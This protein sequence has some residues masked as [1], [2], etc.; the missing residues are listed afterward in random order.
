MNEVEMLRQLLRSAWGR[1]AELQAK[2]NM[3]DYEDIDNHSAEEVKELQLAVSSLR[4]VINELTKERDV[5]TNLI[6]TDRINAVNT[7][8]YKQF[9]ID[10]QDHKVPSPPSPPLPPLWVVSDEGWTNIDEFKM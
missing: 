5:L 10:P 7:L 8:D 9:N 1:E 6:K 3:K 2:I 4:D